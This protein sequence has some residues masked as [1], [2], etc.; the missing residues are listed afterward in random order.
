MGYPF[1][2]SPRGV[3]VMGSRALSEATD[4]LGPNRSRNILEPNQAASRFTSARTLP[5]FHSTRFESRSDEVELPSQVEA[6]PRRLAANE[7]RRA[8]RAEMA[9]LT[10]ASSATGWHI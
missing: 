2:W 6:S 3:L 1:T 7:C 8:S 9:A 10:R 5:S 4:I